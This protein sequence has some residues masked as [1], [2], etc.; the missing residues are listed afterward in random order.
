[1]EEREEVCRAP[2]HWE[3][4]DQTPRTLF[5]ISKQ[6][7]REILLLTWDGI[8]SCKARPIDSGLELSCRLYLHRSFRGHGDTDGKCGIGAVSLERT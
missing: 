7:S 4:Q 8:A 2:F 1:M 6:V 5:Q 3:E